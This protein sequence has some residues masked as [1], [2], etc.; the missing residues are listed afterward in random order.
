MSRDPSRSAR[1]ARELPARPSLE[2][3]KN[4]AKQRLKALRQQSPHAKLTATQL[5]LAREYGSEHPRRQVRR[6]RPRLGGILRPAT[7]RT[8]PPRARR[9]Q[10]KIDVP[11][12]GKRLPPRRRG[13]RL[14][15][16]GRTA[17]LP[18]ARNGAGRIK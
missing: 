10:V 3:L 13:S 9:K 4:E 15:Q 1:R 16:L 17:S 5:A 8:S 6:H 11:N 2:H 12:G 14:R 18:A 7:D